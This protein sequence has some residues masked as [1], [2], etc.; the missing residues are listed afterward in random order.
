MQEAIDFIE[1]CD[2]LEEP[3][4]VRREDGN[5]LVFIDMEEYNNML[6]DNNTD[7]I[8]VKIDSELKAE[9]EVILRDLGL[10]IEEAIRIFLHQ[11]VLYGGI[12]FEIKLAS[13]KSSIMEAVEEAQEAFEGEDER[14]GLKKEED[15]AKMI[16]DVRRER[17]KCKK[18][19][20]RD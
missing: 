1:E 13:V 9:V 19:Q 4:V 3:I 10:T 11:V 2:Y 20:K 5:D 17:K 18:W 14:L 12:P 8:S 6:K 15:V 7:I 16:K